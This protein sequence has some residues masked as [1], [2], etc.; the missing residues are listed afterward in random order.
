MGKDTFSEISEK[1]TSKK[2]KFSNKAKI[3]G[4]RLEAFFK[5]L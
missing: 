3:K 4:L 5:T 2:Y 1:K